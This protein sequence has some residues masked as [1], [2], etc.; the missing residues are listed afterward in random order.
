MLQKGDLVAGA[1]VVVAF[2]AAAVICIVVE[3]IGQEAEGLHIKHELSGIGKGLFFNGGKHFIH[4][5]EITA[6]D[7][8][9]EDLADFYTGDLA[10]FFGHRG[11]ISAEHISDVADKITGHDGIQV[12]DAEALAILVEQDIAD[13]GIVMGDAETEARVGADGFVLSNDMVLRLEV[14]DEVIGLSDTLRVT[15]VQ[16][17][18]EVPVTPGKV[19]KAG[20]GLMQLVCGKTGEQTGKLTELAGCFICLGVIVYDVDGDGILDKRI[21]AEIFVG[22]QPDEVLTVAGR[23]GPGEKDIG[24]MVREPGADLVDIVSYQRRV[25]KDFAVDLLQ[26]KVALLTADE[27]G[28]I[29]EAAAMRGDLAGIVIEAVCRKDRVQHGRMFVSCSFGV[30]LREEIAGI[31]VQTVASLFF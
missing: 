4:L 10:F 17:Q 9:K 19:M 26:D 28:T 6:D 12:Y 5:A 11:E 16:G 3:V 27:P 1:D 24:M 21:K 8:F 31:S 15:V 2:V 20:Q 30:K 7:G 14:S 25:G 13:L 29:D 22:G 23:Y 18:T